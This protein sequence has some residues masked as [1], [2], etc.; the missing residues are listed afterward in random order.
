MF[1]CQNPGTRTAAALAP[2]GG[3]LAASGVGSSA[4][5][6]RTPQGVGEEL[7]RSAGAYTLGKVRIR[8]PRSQLPA[9]RLHGPSELG[10]QPRQAGC[11]GTCPAEEGEEGQERGWEQL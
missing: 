6:G 2:A 5:L 10:C 7:V 8:Q 9:P 3:P 4:P 11:G 1:C